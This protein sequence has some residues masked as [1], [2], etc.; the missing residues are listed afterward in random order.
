MSKLSHVVCI[1]AATLALLAA[2]GSGGGSEET[3]SPSVAATS[4]ARADPLGSAPPVSPPATI[5]TPDPQGNLFGNPN[6]ENGRDPWYSLKQPDFILSGDQAQSGGHSALLQMRDTVDETGAKVYYLVQEI[7]PQDFPEV[8]S[9]YYRVQNWKRGTAKQYM[10]FVVI[11]FDVKNLPENFPNHQIRYPLAG[12]D[13]QPFPIGNAKFVFIS[14]DEPVQGE[15]VHFER[16]IKED[17]Q[18]LWG[19]APQ[20]FTKLRILFEVRY[21]D[22]VAGD[23]APEADVY[24]DDLY[25]G[26]AH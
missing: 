1:L 16:N 14:K 15:W 12:I 7:Q 2:C 18:Q 21:D 25:I 17:F 26:S 11:A 6:F 4:T 5:N 3:S 22:K 19:A 23:G 8:L 20:G 24:Y 10:Q 13:T 9:G